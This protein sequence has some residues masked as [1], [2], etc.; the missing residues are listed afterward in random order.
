[1][2][3]RLQINLKITL[4]HCPRWQPSAHLLCPLGWTEVTHTSHC[5]CN[6][7]SFMSGIT[8]LTF[9]A[10]FR[11]EKL[12]WRRV[13][14]NNLN[15]KPFLKSLSTVTDGSSLSAAGLTLANIRRRRPL[16]ASR[17]WHRLRRSIRRYAH[18]EPAH[19]KMLLHLKCRLKWDPMD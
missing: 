10:S 11:T 19:L 8:L 3:W 16:V 15:K 13:S 12:E 4:K 7:C 2:L 17:R 1:M 9:K 5:L 18:H 6:A 14:V